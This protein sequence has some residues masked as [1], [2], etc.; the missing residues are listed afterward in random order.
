MET[1]KFYQKP[2]QDRP[3][4][5]NFAHEACNARWDSLT[6]S[7]KCGGALATQQEADM[8]VHEACYPDSMPYTAYGDC[9]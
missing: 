3:Y 2:L 7:G 9:A 5:A 6:P 1:C 4:N 8:R